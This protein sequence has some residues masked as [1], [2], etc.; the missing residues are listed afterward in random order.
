MSF[1]NLSFTEVLTQ[2]MNL[3]LLAV[4]IAAVIFISY[5]LIRILKKH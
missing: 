5:Q 3:V 2:W 4:V 1:I